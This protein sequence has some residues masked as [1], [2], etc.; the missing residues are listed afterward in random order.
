MVC[1]G[2]LSQDVVAVCHSF[3][4]P[5]LLPAVELSFRVALDTWLD[6]WDV[7]PMLIRWIMASSAADDLPVNAKQ[8]L[9][10]LLALQDVKDSDYFTDMNAPLDL[11]ELWKHV[12]AT[13][14]CPIY[15]TYQHKDGEG[16]AYEIN[17]DMEPAV[18]KRLMALVSSSSIPSKNGV[19]VDVHR[20]RRLGG[21]AIF[22]V[23]E[24]PIPT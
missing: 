24:S 16:D 3:I 22:S 4:T 6:P 9:W 17:T 2:G 11:D 1:I 5:Q 10:R 21:R 7:K 12:P 15:P 14:Q 19:G 20:S 13:V 8:S 18:A 23:G